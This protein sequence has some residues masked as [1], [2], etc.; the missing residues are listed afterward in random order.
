MTSTPSASVTSSARSAIAYLKSQGWSDTQAAALVGNFQAE[1]GVN[2]D[3]NAL[4]P[5]GTSYGI[6]Q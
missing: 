6:A 5:D 4:S 1:S 3:P 2:L